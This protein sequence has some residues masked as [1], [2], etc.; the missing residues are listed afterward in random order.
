MARSSTVVKGL[1]LN[2]SPHTTNRHVAT[3]ML[4]PISGKIQLR[5]KCFLNPP[6]QRGLNEI[7]PLG[8]ALRLEAHQAAIAATLDAMRAIERHGGA[9]IL[10]RAFLGFQCLPAPNTWRAVLHY[11]DDDQP[12]LTQVRRV[13]RDY[14]KEVHPDRVG[15]VTGA[16]P[17]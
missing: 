15:A 2:S 12:T 8:L 14:A 9:T 10:D 5:M 17:N 11:Q 3:W 16:W 6:L 13:Y 1:E 7:L 4:R